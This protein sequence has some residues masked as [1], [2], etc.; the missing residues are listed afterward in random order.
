MHKV[1]TRQGWCLTLHL[2]AYAQAL[3]AGLKALKVLGITGIAVDLHW[4]LVEGSEPGSYNWKGYRQ[5]TDSC[6]RFP[7][8]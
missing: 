4:G 8:C 3:T 2:T 7:P 1:I 5:V 6:N